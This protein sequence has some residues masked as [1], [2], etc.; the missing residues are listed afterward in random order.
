MEKGSSSAVEHG[1]KRKG[2]RVKGN[3]G[4]VEG[5]RTPSRQRETVQRWERETRVLERKR[6]KESWRSREMVERP[7][8]LA[9][10]DCRA[11]R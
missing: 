6:E 8:R 1:A 11:A 3:S 2:L 10:V 9:F 4:S 5:R 7:A